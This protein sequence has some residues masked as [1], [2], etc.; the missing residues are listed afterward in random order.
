MENKS[1]FKST[2]VSTGTVSESTAYLKKSELPKNVSAFRNDAEYISSSALDEWLKS[3]SYISKSEIETLIKRANLVVIDTVHNTSDSASI[4][5]LDEYDNVLRG[6]IVAIKDRLNQLDGTF[7]S[8][9]KEGDFATKTDITNVENNITN[10]QTSISQ[11]ESEKG[12][13]LTEHQSLE[14]YAKKSDIPSL[15]GYV[16]TSDLNNKV[17]QI[18]TSIE[19]SVDG[20]ASEEWVNEQGFLTEHQSLDDYATKYWVE[21]K[22]Y[23]KKSDI[24]SLSSYAKKSELDSKIS[25]VRTQ[26]ETSIEGLASEQWVED[27]GYL[28]K[29]QSLAGYAKKS[30]LDT[31]IAQVRT[32]IETSLDGLATEQWVEGKGYLTEHQSLEDYAK[33]S[34]IPSLSG[35]AKKSEITNALKEY[36]LKDSVYDKTYID[37]TVDTLLSK[38]DASKTYPTKKDVKN[39]YLNKVDA[40]NQ[41][42]KIE[43]YR[44][45]KNAATINTEYKTKDKEDLIRDKDSLMN[46]FYLVNYADVVIVKDHEILSMFKDGFINGFSAYEIA[47]ENGFDGTEE[48]WLTSLTGATGPK[49][50]TGA[51]GPKGETGD[52]G[53]KGDTGETG[54]SAYAIAVENGFEGTV[55]EWLESL[56]STA[57][58]THFQWQNY[59]I[60]V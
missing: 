9:D 6:E 14:D 8:L 29:H 30:D 12:N 34:D 53:A 48:E 44:G 33:K 24:P 20:L 58:E 57:T 51:T 54:K 11:L 47:L 17:A 2:T 46:G 37:D 4:A 38:E 31:K 60:N 56:K 50:D 25:Q 18:R 39:T 23:A 13:Y 26:L 7:I 49:G 52:K 28:T 59:P 55:T 16:K 15:S 32:Q 19:N 5:R 45:L 42:L 27:K 10:I 21:G 40:A 35:Y 41:Y 43:D 36:A 22:G 3:H 1:T